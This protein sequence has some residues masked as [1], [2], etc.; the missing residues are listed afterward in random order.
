MI[1]DPTPCALCGHADRYLDYPG[2]CNRCALVL[3]LMNRDVK[4]LQRMQRYV[5][6]DKDHGAT[7]RRT[8]ESVASK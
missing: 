8:A 3:K 4:L 6:G 5:E 1:G 7:D 2:L